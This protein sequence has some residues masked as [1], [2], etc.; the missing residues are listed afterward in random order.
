MELGSTQTGK[1]RHEQRECGRR[2]GEGRG[3]GGVCVGGGDGGGGIGVG[4]NG[5][6]DGGGNGSG[7]DWCPRRVDK[8]S[9]EGVD[10][11]VQVPGAQ[12]VMVIALVCARHRVRRRVIALVCARH[13]V[14]RRVMGSV[15]GL[16][17]RCGRR[18]RIQ[19]LSRMLLQGIGVGGSAQRRRRPKEVREC[20]RRGRRAFRGTS[21]A[22]RSALAARD[23]KGPDEHLPQCCGC[24]LGGGL[25][26]MAA[27]RTEQA[28]DLQ[29]KRRRR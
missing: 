8:R 1:H 13:R 27:Q 16:I 22:L 6:D 2:G 21:S 28:D 15:M 4:N 18:R 5:G 14:R 26:V 23:G 29:V 25:G 20:R 24:G 19:L 11:T 17:G 10:A 3:G 12:H 9:G 7:A